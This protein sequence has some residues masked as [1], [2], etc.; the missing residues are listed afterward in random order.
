MHLHQVAES[1]K[2]KKSR[3]KRVDD[4]ITLTNFIVHEVLLN[5][6]LAMLLHQVEEA[7]GTNIHIFTKVS[8]MFK[9]A[10]ETKD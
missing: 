9:G 8:K 3:E 7:L 5:E 6:L 2:G 10:N 1:A 4:E